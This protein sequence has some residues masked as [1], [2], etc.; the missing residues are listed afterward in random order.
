MRIVLKSD[1]SNLE[2]MIKT[3][4]D[5]DIFEPYFNIDVEGLSGGG[6]F[7]HSKSSAED[8][9]RYINAAFNKGRSIGYNEGYMDS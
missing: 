6:C 2:D 9:M 7:V 3:V 8:V 4:G 1:F 5:A